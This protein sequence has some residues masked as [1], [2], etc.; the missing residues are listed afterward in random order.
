MAKSTHFCG[1]LEMLS[2]LSLNASHID[3]GMEQKVPDCESKDSKTHLKAKGCC[4]NEFEILNMD[5]DF[6]I[7]KATFNLH[8]NFAVAFV[9]TFI[10]NSSLEVPLNSELPDY[11]PPILKRDHQVLFQT[12]LI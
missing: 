11:Y 6:S 5:E 10:F 4:D 12:F 8:L 3:C 2:E 7:T 9:H 1:G